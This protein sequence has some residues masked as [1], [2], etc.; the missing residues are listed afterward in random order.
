MIGW[1][2]DPIGK[3]F[4][5]SEFND[6]TWVPRTGKIVGVVEDFNMES[7]YNKVEPVVYYIS[8]TW[9]NWMTLRINGSR[10]PATID[11]IKDKWVQYG[12]EEAFDYA[13][14]D[15][16]IDQLYQGEERYFKL[17]VAFTIL[18]IFIASLGI[19]GLSAFTAEQRRKEIGIRKVFGAS[20][21]HLVVLLSKEFTWLVLIGFGLAIPIAYYVMSLWLADFIYRIEFGIMPFLIAGSLALAIAWLTVSFQSVKA[22]I[23]N[24]VNT[25]HYE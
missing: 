21:S 7:L 6:G 11:F 1:T 19:F 5:T 13:F 3:W 10:T 4:E 9:L 20:V 23:E 24:P 14:L 25:L 15:D 8:K 17:F 2:D 18:A 22:A 16:R 12:P